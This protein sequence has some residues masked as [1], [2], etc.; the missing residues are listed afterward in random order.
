M[1]LFLLG[2]VNENVKEMILF[3]PAR[4]LFPTSPPHPP[5]TPYP[6]PLKQLD[7]RMLNPPG[8]RAYVVLTGSMVDKERTETRRRCPAHSIVASEGWRLR[9][10]AR[11]SPASI[12]S[13]PLPLL[14]EQPGASHKAGSASGIRQGLSQ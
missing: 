14:Q 12:L 5:P 6:H 9:D 3:P 1:L 4:R 2:V 13:H 11:S 7:A 10:S 8:R